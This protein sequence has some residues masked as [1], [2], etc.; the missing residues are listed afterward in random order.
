MTYTDWEQLPFP[1]R[2]TVTPTR[3]GHEAHLPCPGEWLTETRQG[4][5]IQ[6]AVE[7]ARSAYG[8]DVEVNVLWTCDGDGI[9]SNYE[10]LGPVEED[11]KTV[12]KGAEQ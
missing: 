3:V 12:M 7:D 10:L 5:F 4:D 2:G 1:V 6:K 11:G 8:A 9:C